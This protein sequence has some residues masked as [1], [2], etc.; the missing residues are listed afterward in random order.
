VTVYARH[1]RGFEDGVEVFAFD[2]LPSGIRQLWEVR[3]R[4]A[5]AGDEF[6]DIWTVVGDPLSI[7][8]TGRELTAQFG[9]LTDEE[10]SA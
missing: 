4:I 3:T 7:E 2:E 8:L 10:P 9:P 1:S 6:F 5:W